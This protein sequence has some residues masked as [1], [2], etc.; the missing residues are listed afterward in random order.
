M[1]PLFQRLGIWMGEVSKYWLAHPYQN[2]L[3]VTRPPKSQVYEW[4]RFRNT[5][6]HT[7]TKIIPK[8]P[9]PPS[10]RDFDQLV[11]AFAVHMFRDAGFP[12][13]DSYFY[14]I[15]TLAPVYKGLQPMYVSRGRP[16]EL[17]QLNNVYGRL[18]VEACTLIFWTASEKYITR[19]HGTCIE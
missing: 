16:S 5:G 4:G 3:Q 8:L 19:I 1:G 6:S 2:Y 10:P 17:K 14:P 13:H 9:A 11:W 7:R 15:S 12:Y 18:L